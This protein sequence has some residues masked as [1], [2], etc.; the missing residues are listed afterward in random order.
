MNTYTSQQNRTVRSYRALAHSILALAII[1]PS[2]S[3]AFDADLSNQ[4]TGSDSSNT[5]TVSETT[6]LSANIT[7]TAHVTN[8][9]AFHLNTGGNTIENNT[10]VGDVTTGDVNVDLVA[11]T[12]VNEVDQNQLQNL[13]GQFGD[14]STNVSITNSNTGANSTNSNQFSQQKNSNVQVN[15]TMNVVNSLALDANTGNNNISNNTTVGDITTGDI[16]VNATVQTEGNGVGGGF[17]PKENPGSGNDNGNSTGNTVTIAQLPT[18]QIAA[19]TPT[20]KTPVTGQGGGFF[21]AGS[22]SNLPLEILAFVLA[23]IVVIRFRELSPLLFS[24]LQ[25]Q[26][27]T[28]KVR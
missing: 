12:K 3:Y 26:P 6:D 15:N 4:D 17:L 27:V 11:D 18:S 24:R 28:V 20:V 21:P 9:F 7:N 10:T 22:D 14:T 8:S 2:S 16:S 25:Q 19:L 1:L 5:N 13:L 23:A